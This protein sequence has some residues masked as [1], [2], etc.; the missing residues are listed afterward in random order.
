[1]HDLIAAAERKEYK[2]VKEALKGMLSGIDWS[3]DAPPSATLERDFQVGAAISEC[4]AAGWKLKPQDHD[5]HHRLLLLRL[6]ALGGDAKAETERDHFVAAHG[7]TAAAEL[8]LE[9]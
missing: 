4:T 9:D 8:G 3:D 7:I 6:R 1:M 5:Y 2:M